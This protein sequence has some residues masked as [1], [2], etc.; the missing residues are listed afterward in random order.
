MVLVSE[1]RRS[2]PGPAR[3][4][5]RTG[6]GPGTARER[7]PWEPYRPAPS[8][9]AAAHRRRSRSRPVR[10]REV[11]PASR[12]GRTPGDR[13]TRSSLVPH[14]HRASRG[15]SSA[16]RRR[17]P[18]RGSIRPP[19]SRRTRRDA[20]GARRSRARV[21]R[22]RRARSCPRHRTV[23]GQDAGPRPPF[24]PSTYRQDIPSARALRPF[25][26]SGRP[27]NPLLWSTT[28]RPQRV[29]RRSWLRVSRSTRAAARRGD[30][31]AAPP[32]PDP[33]DPAA[34]SATRAS[35]RHPAR[36]TVPSCPGTDRRSPRSL[37]ATTIVLIRRSPSSSPPDVE[38]SARTV[39]TP[40]NI[41]PMEHG[42]TDERVSTARTRSSRSAFRPTS[43]GV[44]GSAASD[45]WS[46]ANRSHAKTPMIP[47][48]TKAITRPT[49]VYRFAI[50][51]Q[52]A[53]SVTRSRTC[54][55]PPAT[56]FRRGSG[57]S[58]VPVADHR[59][60]PVALTERSE[61]VRARSRAARPRRRCRAARSRRCAARSRR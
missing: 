30:L 23:R 50:S 32:P 14:R 59:T 40:S 3:S 18:P 7:S 45:S 35:G 36:T 39:G 61:H 25:T 37:G 6:S 46:D 41:S 29:W 31:R 44:D 8:G 26:G 51:R 22:L 38:Q 33:S 42:A 47:P 20:R 13:S 56:A 49:A 21:F 16:A 5:M 1:D 60:E 43:A 11:R 53:R 27:E 12:P 2:R 58:T 34:R 15:R 54:A 9:P 17:R 10:R 55:Q 48:S 4:E 52:Y 19:R 28:N 24:P 57:R